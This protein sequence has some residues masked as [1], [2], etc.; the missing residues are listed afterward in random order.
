MNTDSSKHL[1]VISC[2]VVSRELEVAAAH[3]PH[4]LEFHI[5]SKGLHDI[6]CAGMRERLQEAIDQH[7]TSSHDAVLLG[8]ALCNNGIVGLKA[9]AHCPL[10]VTRAHDCIT[11]FMGS[12]QRYADYFQQHP[13]TF[14]LTPGWIEHGEEKGDLRQLTMQSRMG[15]NDTYDELVAKYG[16][17]NAEFLWEELHHPMEHYSG[18][19]YIDTGA[20]PREQFEPEARKRADKEGWKF[21]SLSG[22]NRLFNAF[23][24]GHWNEEDFLIV[25]PGQII[26]ATHDDSII[27]A[28]VP[29]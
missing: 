19:T 9:P 15:M 28:E 26:Q 11:L 6:G 25:P 14:F 1:L 12:R 5:L 17:D 21:E 20:A 23:A 7:V 16:E 22:D 3:S 27:R 18:L 24:S 8:Y 13:G 4:K 29:K 10:I 2:A